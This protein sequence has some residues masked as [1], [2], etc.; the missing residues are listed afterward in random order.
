MVLQLSPQQMP[1]LYLALLTFWLGSINIP[2]R[3][4]HR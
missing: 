2:A 1:T 4:L 3:P